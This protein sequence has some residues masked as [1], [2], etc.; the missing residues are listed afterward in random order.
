LIGEDN[1]KA[2]E[3]VV[4]LIRRQKESEENMVKAVS[5]L[6]ARVNNEGAKL[7]LTELRLDST[8]HAQICQEI[9]SLAERTPPARL[10]D[11]RIEGFVD[12][13]VVRKELERHILLE[14]AMLK[15]VEQIIRE[16]KDEAIRLLFTHI[17]EDEKKHHKNVRLVIDRSY[18]FAP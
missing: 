5:A 11:A 7:I 12:M 6:E 9:L 10:W 17:A 8:K 1:M 3:S 2:E 16:S 15:D 4:K 14:E 13:Q 18:T